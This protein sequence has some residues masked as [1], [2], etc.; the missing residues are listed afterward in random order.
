MLLGLKILLLLLFWTT[1]D[2]ARVQR[3]DDTVTWGSGAAVASAESSTRKIA[4]RHRIG[5]SR[6]GGGDDR[7]A[8]LQKCIKVF[9]FITTILALDQSRHRTHTPS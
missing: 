8:R 9:V 7:G 2:G 5:R 4:V 3:V 6:G 1:N